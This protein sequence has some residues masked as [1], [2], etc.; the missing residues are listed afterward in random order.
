ML[1]KSLFL[2]LFLIGSLQQAQAFNFTS[3]EQMSSIFISSPSGVQTMI[4]TRQSILTELG[5]KPN[6]T[7]SEEVGNKIFDREEA[8]AKKNKEANKK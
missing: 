5:L 7:T 4:T 3:G 8:I 1:A 6:E 2:T